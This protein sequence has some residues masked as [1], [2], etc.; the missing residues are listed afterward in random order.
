LSG[1]FDGDGRTDLAVYSQRE[2][3]YWIGSVTGDRLNWRLASNTAGYGDLWDG[4]HLLEAGQWSGSGRSLLLFNYGRDGNWFMGTFAATQVYWDRVATTPALGVLSDGQHL[5][6]TGDFDGNGST[7]LLVFAR[8]AADWFVGRYDPSGGTF[9]PLNFKRASNTAIFGDLMDANHRVWAGAFSRAGRSDVLTYASNGDWRL[10]TYDPSKPEGSQ[11]TWTFVENTSGFGSLVDGAHEFLTG[12]FDGDRLTD[13]AFYYRGDGNWW[14]RRYS[15][16]TSSWQLMGNTATGLGNLLDGKHRLLTADIDGDGQTDVLLFGRQ[17]PHSWQKAS[18]NRTTH[19]LD[20]TP[21]GGDPFTSDLPDRLQNVWPGHFTQS[22]RDQL[23][24]RD[25]VDFTAKWWL[26]TYEGQKIT[27][28]ELTEPAT[29]GSFVYAPGSFTYKP[30]AVNGSHSNSR[31][32][33]IVELRG[34]IA[35]LSDSANG[36]DP[37][38]WHYVLEPDARWMDSVGMDLQQLMRVG[39]ILIRHSGAQWE[40]VSDASVPVELNSWGTSQMGRWGNVPPLRPFGWSI[41]DATKSSVWP[42]DPSKPSTAA[43]GIGAYV[44]MVGSLIT[45]DPHWGCDFP[46]CWC[47]GP[48]WCATDFV[49]AARMWGKGFAADDPRNPARWTEMHP[50]DTIQVLPPKQRVETLR[51]VALGVDDGFFTNTEAVDFFIYPP[52]SRPSAPNWTLACRESVGPETD[53]STLSVGNPARTGALIERVDA[54][55]DRYGHT[56]GGAACHIRAAVTSRS[57]F[58]GPGRFKAIYRVFWTPA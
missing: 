23:L 40:A 13:I 42:F 22:D 44:R 47:D 16:G 14:L 58:R 46:G 54:V 24:V 57:F 26:G 52:S 10:A 27:W 2:R 25:E 56:I 3:V 31:G 50:P 12:D 36:D 1:D 21:I 32:S 43:I 19:V 28:T 39:T 41:R 8:A 55:V 34:W 51:A 11:L 7:D 53:L 4:D 37:D 48:F 20:W 35:K 18:Y 38:D 6:K 17:Q 30:L 33:Q 49:N 15:V 5:V 45:D 29:P 9:F